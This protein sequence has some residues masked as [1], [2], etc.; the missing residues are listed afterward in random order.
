MSEEA[1][2]LGR[3]DSAK[4]PDGYKPEDLMAQDYILEMILVATMGEGDDS[5][6]ELSLTLVIDGVCISGLAISAK[7]WAKGVRQQMGEH[8]QGG[9]EFE[10]FVAGIYSD[11][12]AEAERRANSGPLIPP[13]N[14]VHMKDAVVG[15][16]LGAYPVPLWRGS[17]R[18]VSGW[19]IGRITR[20]KDKS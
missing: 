17:L 1:T 20:D 15:N 7:A 19:A 2:D 14:F 13:M 18:K 16:G 10:E 6:A 4:D 9:A 3:H 5:D 11:K 12:A 8:T